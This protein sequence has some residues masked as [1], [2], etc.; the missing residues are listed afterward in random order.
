M[1][2][3]SL[4]PWEKQELIVTQSDMKKFGLTD[5]QEVVKIAQE[6]ATYVKSQNLSTVIQNKDYVLVEG[7]QFAAGL[8]GLTG[9]IVSYKNESSYAPVEFKWMAWVNRQKVEKKHSTK[10]YKY[11]AEAQFVSY[12]DGKESIMSQAFAMCSNEETAKH[13]FDEYSILSMAQTRAIGKAARMSFAF[14]IKA[15][16]YEPTPAEEMQGME[17]AES[18]VEET[19]LPEDVFN[20]I[21]TFTD[22]LDLVEW[23][24]Q[25]TEWIPNMKFSRLVREQ[26]KVLA[27]KQK[28]NGKK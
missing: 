3:N 17:E 13:T 26:I 28:E 19:D 12:K 2:E 6:V 20:T 23:A 27:K 10:L 4:K 14:L 8:L 9:K 16:G 21:Y 15:A 1:E 7:W 5:P 22:Q 24:N 25:Q 18:Q 11:F